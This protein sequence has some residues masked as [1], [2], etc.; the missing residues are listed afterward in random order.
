[1]FNTP[2]Y[3]GLLRKYV[4]LCGTLV[5]NI[6]ITRTDS[7]G[8]QTALL[9]VPVTYAPKDKMLSRVV[10][11]PSLDRPSATI[12]LPMISFEMGKMQYDGTRKLNTVGRIAIKDS[13]DSNKFKYQYNPVP[14]N[15]DFKVYVYAK[16]AEDGTKIIEQILPY[17]TPDWTT[18]VHLIPEMEITMDI[19]I[20]LNDIS[21]SDNYDLDFKERR[22]IIWTLDLTLKGYLYG[23]VKKSGIIKFI[24]TNFYT[25]SVA[26]GKMTTAVGV[27]P[28]AEKMTIQPG[29]TA[30]GQPINYYG[31]ISNTGTIPYNEIEI[32]DDFGYITQ[33]FQIDEPSDYVYI[34]TNEG[35]PLTSSSEEN[36]LYTNP[37]FPE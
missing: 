10:Q 35:D 7:F 33:I 22:A 18:T 20:I 34:T 13:T 14:Y 28:I 8:N 5:N 6:Y 25:P 9:R 19:P 12:P 29:L 11:D 37:I 27:T 17:F 16:N 36:P 23:P 1:M 21:Y 32:T 4:I 3:F 31:G 2:F 30:N 24:N 26:D 15:I